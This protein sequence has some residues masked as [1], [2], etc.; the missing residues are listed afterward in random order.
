MSTSKGVLFFRLMLF[1][2]SGALIAFLALVTRACCAYIGGGFHARAFLE[3]LPALPP[4]LF[5][6]LTLPLLLLIAMLALTLIRERWTHAGKPRTAALLWPLD[7]LLC[8]GILVCT[9][10]SFSGVMLLGVTNAIVYFS[11]DSKKGMLLLVPMLILYLLVDYSL[12]SPLMP[13]TSLN[14]YVDMLPRVARALVYAARNIMT[15]MVAL[16]TILLTVQIARRQARENKRIAELNQQLTR[17]ADELRLANLQL[18]DYAERSIEMGRVR[19]RNRLA[20]EIHDTIGHTL[21]AISTGLQAVRATLSI[22]PIRSAEQIDRIAELASTGLTDVRRSVR[23]LRPD[24]LERHTLIGALANMADQLQSSTG[25]E[26]TLDVDPVRLSGDEEETIYR[27]VQESATNAIRHGHAKRIRVR[28]KQFDTHILIEI[29]DDGDGCQDVEEGFG[30][31]HIRE[32]VESLGG[33][34][35]HVGNHAGG[36]RVCAHLTLRKG[37]EL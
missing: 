10:F 19:E 22:D 18:H 21:T 23:E 8:A 20:R 6:S 3:K 24:A 34:M 12:L 14:T 28:L 15:S 17:A 29:W 25:T 13:L 33:L 9:E 5:K 37:V 36:F 32:R 7:L 4:S 11:L 30:L 27:I 16:L 35:M 26:L 2:L 1:A 31:S